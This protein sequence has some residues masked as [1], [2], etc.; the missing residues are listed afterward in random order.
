MDSQVFS[1]TKFERSVLQCLLVFM[2]QLSHTYMTIGKNIDLI[3]WIFVDKVMF[4][5]FNVLS[6]FVI[7]FLPRSKYLLISWVQSLST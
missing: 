3:M 4:L 5:L 6:R 7:A 1:S 2:D